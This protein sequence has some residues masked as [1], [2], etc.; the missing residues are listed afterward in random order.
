MERC[1]ARNR[2]RVFVIVI[3]VVV[4]LVVM[5][6]MVVML[7]PESRAPKGRRQRTRADD[8]NGRAGEQRDPREEALRGEPGGKEE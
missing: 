5:V 3:V 4:V 7:V 6:A 8:G 1:R 2:V